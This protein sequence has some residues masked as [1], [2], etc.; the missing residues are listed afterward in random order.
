M[1]TKVLLVKRN[2]K[3]SLGILEGPPPI[4]FKIANQIYYRVKWGKVADDDL[5]NIVEVYEERLKSDVV[6][7][8]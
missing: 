7:R 8:K 6:P 2:G 3:T 4:S 1:E 5:T